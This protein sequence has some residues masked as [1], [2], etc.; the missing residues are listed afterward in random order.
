[1]S[2]RVLTQGGGAGGGE[3]ASIFVTGLSESD[4]V[5]AV[6]NEKTMSCVWNNAESR[7]EITGIKKYGM[8]TVTATNG[9]NITTKNVLVDMAL[10][11]EIEMGYEPSYIKLFDDGNFADYTATYKYRAYGSSYYSNVSYSVSSSGISIAAKSTGQSGYQIDQGIDFTDYSIMTARVVSVSGSCLV[12]LYNP[13]TSGLGSSTYTFKL[14]NGSAIEHSRTTTGV[15]I[16]DI[17]EIVGTWYPAVSRYSG[18][19]D[20]VTRAVFDDWYI[21]KFDDLQTLCSIVGIDAP[22]KASTLV[23]DTEA[24]NYIL[25]NS[26]AVRYMVNNCTGDFMACAVHS[27]TFL[28]V[29]DASPYKSVVFANEHWSKFL[30]M[31][32]VTA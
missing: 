22:S 32:G 18:N 4:T 11:Y 9:E 28:S 5:T 8:V 17:G 29:L 16:L 1:M 10:V 31:V 2:L 24:V 14:S 21:F 20:S 3:S 25:S 26:D 15:F 13:V 7:F 6:L 19:S 23:A 12:G 30:T 27:T